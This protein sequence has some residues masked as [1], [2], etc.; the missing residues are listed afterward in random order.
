MQHVSRDENTIANNLAQQAL[1]FDQI[2][3]NLVI[4][5]N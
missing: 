2:V 3:E 4:W 1:G 5:K